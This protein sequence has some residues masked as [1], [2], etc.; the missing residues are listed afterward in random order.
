MVRYRTKPE[1]AEENARL[2]Q[3]MFQELR[4]KSPDGVRYLALRLSDGTFINARAR[5][6]R[7]ADRL[8]P[9]PRSAEAVLGIVFVGLFINAAASRARR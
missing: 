3:A 4:A 6:H 5:R 9:R 1:T 8:G 2:I 7:T